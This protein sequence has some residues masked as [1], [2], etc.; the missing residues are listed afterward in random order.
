MIVQCRR[1]QKKYRLDD[2]RLEAG[3]LRVQCPNCKNIFTVSKPVARKEEP[4]EVVRQRP[5]PGAAEGPIIIKT[6]VLVE[7][8]I[9][10]RALVGFLGEKP[11]YGWWDS[12]FLSETGLRFL[13]VIFP[14]S[15]FA[16]GVN[17]VTE[18][19]KRLHDSRIGKGRVYHLFRLPSRFEHIIHED[20]LN[21]DQSK[22]L[23]DL[24]TKEAAL[25]KLQT[26]ASSDFEAPEGPI[27]IGTSEDLTKPLSVKKLAKY[28][29]DAFEVGKRTFPYFV[30][31]RNG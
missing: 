11:Q 17:S 7:K 19:A 27:Q 1:C 31:V 3:P 8:L 30:E 20:L 5:E 29:G 23:P 21:F 10:L 9:M 15:A 13:D 6:H 14:R 28:Y 16:A 2:S 24:E 26:F 4:A 18:A 22:L 25:G 12:N